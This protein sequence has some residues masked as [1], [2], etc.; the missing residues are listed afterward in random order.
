M[1]VSNKAGLGECKG[2]RSLRL[3]IVTLTM[4]VAGSPATHA[5]V[6]ADFKAARSEY[7]SKRLDRFARHAARIPKDDLLYSYIRYWRLRA[8]NA[9]PDEMQVFLDAYPESPLSDRLRSELAGL[10]AMAENWPA[11]RLHYQ[12][13][14][15]PSQDL[16][17]I[18][19]HLRVREGTRQAAE[20]AAKLWQSDK[21]LPQACT[22][23]F[24]TLFEQGRL[25]QEDRYRRLR[26]ALDGGNLALAQS[27]DASLPEGER[28]AENTLAM[29]QRRGDE[30]IASAP[31][32]RAAREA[33]LYALTLFAKLD[34]TDAARLWEAHAG[35]Y[36]ESEQRYGWGQIALHAARRH[37]PAAPD[38]FTRSGPAE[39]QAG[40]PLQAQWRARAALRAGKWLEVYQTIQAM[41]ASQ[42][43]ESVWRYWKAR[44]LKALNALYPANMLFAQ[45]S[46]EADYYGFLS[47]EELPPR[48][49]SRPQPTRLTPEEQAW[50]ESHPPLRLALR[51]REMDLP[52]D[53]Q[54]E[55]MRAIQNLSDRKLM[56]AADLALRAGWYDR[57]INTANRTRVEHNYDLRFI[58]PYRDLASAQASEQGLDEAWV[59]GLIRQE[60]R[61]VSHA[62]SGVGAQGLMQIMPATARWIAG[63]L[64][65]DRRAHAKMGQP[66][67][68]IR[69][70]TY[71]LKRIYEALDQSPVLA[72]AGYNA[73][74]GRARKWQAATP[75]EGAI[76]VESIPF[77]ET[78]DYVK[79]VLTNAMFYRQRF[80]GETLRLK[81]R[82]G[83]IPARKS[84]APASSDEKDPA[85]TP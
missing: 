33:A 26:L 13:L 61:F 59:F 36:S 23:L 10:Y 70:G 32:R 48:L 2:W 42:Q 66:E 69:F 40:S 41:P 7:Q 25:T 75:L 76:Y 45:L 53:A 71:Y 30:L 9:T 19:L 73:G 11:F 54:E 39:A 22:Q 62:R 68:N 83:V 47:L 79:R 78:R 37:D 1:G 4:L 57:A 12:T 81:D 27:L 35:K 16:A 24:N 20:D 67:T 29:A 84:D 6:E 34:P 82:L 8:D 44:A 74:P 3:A 31:A 43:E 18:D 51:L 63:Q 14:A 49:E 38:W 64:G 50:A 85:P 17:C 77:Q 21:S 46:Q 65:L 15:K 56:A 60:S 5:G 72:T 52:A 58:A 55:W 80:G 28:M